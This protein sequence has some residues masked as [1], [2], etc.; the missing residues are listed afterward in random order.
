MSY[1][2]KNNQTPQ[3]DPYGDYCND[4]PA[5]DG[6]YGTDDSFDQDYDSL[7]QDFGVDPND[8]SFVNGGDGTEGPQQFS[9][10]KDIREYIQNYLEPMLKVSTL[11]ADDQKKIQEEID[12][13]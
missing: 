12:T 1:P 4:N 2:V 13:L 8:D 7:N 9:S 5:S 11:S 10:A 3:N 6:D